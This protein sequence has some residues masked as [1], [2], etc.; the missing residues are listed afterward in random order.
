[1]HMDDDSNLFDSIGSPYSSPV[2]SRHMSSQSHLS[3]HGSTSGSIARDPFETFKLT[4]ILVGD[5][6][7][8]SE[9]AAEKPGS[10]AGIRHD[11]STRL[12]RSQLNALG[13]RSNDEY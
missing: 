11:R 1:M 8:R 13:G 4:W 9:L 7:I 10:R 6:S 3:M 2:L 5:N 12:H